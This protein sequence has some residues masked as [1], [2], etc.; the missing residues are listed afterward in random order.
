[1]ALCT[2]AD[3]EAKLH[4]TDLSPVASIVAELIIDAQ[5][6]VES[7]IGRRV[8][9]AAYT[10]VFDA[11]AASLWLTHWPVT[12][13]AEVREDGTVL[14]AAGYAWYESGQVTRLRGDHRSPWLTTKP[15]AIEV[16]YTGGFS[17]PTYDLEL[18]HL[19][20]LCAE[21]VA[22]AFRK[23]AAAD[24][25]PAGAAG[26]IQSVSLDGLGT[27]TYETGTGSGAAGTVGTLVYL[28]PDQLAQLTRYQAAGVA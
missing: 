2:Q 10:E 15:Q 9:S 5:A 1:M 21:V 12:A 17:S 16:D 28:D 22:R 20:S 13:V 14:A 25:L 3:V 27:I 11:P 23:S 4:G 6:L 19:K 18:D 24:A 8:E 26:D 7:D